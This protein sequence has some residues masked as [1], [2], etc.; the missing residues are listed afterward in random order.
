MLNDFYINRR[1]LIEPDSNRV[2]DKNQDTA[3]RT[4]AR[5]M[6][7][8]LILSRNAGKTVTRE[9]LVTDIWQDYGGG[10][11]GLTQSISVLR[12]ILRDADKTMIKTVPKKGYLFS[13]E[14]TTTE[15]NA[16]AAG[17]Q[18]GHDRV[19]R[20]KKKWLIAGILTAAA[21]IICLLLLYNPKKYATQPA[22]PVTVP[23]P[24]SLAREEQLQENEFTTIVTRDA[25]ST[26][27][28]LVVTGDH[29]PKFFVNNLQL[30]EDKWEPYMPL[31]NS[32]KRQLAEKQKQVP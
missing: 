24:D 21:S 5:I 11:E 19:R 10:D 6:Q 28:K 4:E 17:I 27:Y 25:D 26:A 29:P 9:E 13:G 30:P 15:D 12:K 20:V 7:L 31:I 14:I 2:T 1:F 16:A 8:L 18:P 3:T 22:A 32:L 23:F